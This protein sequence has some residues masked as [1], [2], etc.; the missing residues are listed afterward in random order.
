MV[1][2]G[3]GDRGILAG[4]GQPHPGRGIDGYDLATNR[5]SDV[6]VLGD[7]DRVGQVAHGHVCRHQGSLLARVGRLDP[8]RLPVVGAE[9]AR[10]HLKRSRRPHRGGG[11]A[12]S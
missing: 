3:S 2:N 11:G 12:K 10:R 1:R 5:F 6:V 4:S 8:K 7:G 9:Q